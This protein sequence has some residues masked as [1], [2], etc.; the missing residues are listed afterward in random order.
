MAVPDESITTFD[1][2]E[3]AAYLLILPRGKLS[4]AGVNELK[5]FA[6]EKLMFSTAVE[7][8]ID[9]K[10]QVEVDTTLI[11]TLKHFVQ[12]AYHKEKKVI[13]TAPNELYKKAIQLAGLSTAIKIH[14]SVEEVL[15]ARSTDNFPKHC[16][17][18]LADDMATQLKILA[19]YL[20]DL[21]YRNM[22]Q[23]QDG[24]AAWQA[25]DS[26][27]NNN[28]PFGLII[29]DWYMPKLSGLELL[30]KIRADSR[31][32]DIPFIMQTTEKQMAN[33]SIAVQAGVDSYLIK[34]FGAE[35]IKQKMARVWESRNPKP[36]LKTHKLSAK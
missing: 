23:V 21:G 2:E 12:L 28:K 24:E 22:E 4:Y 5:T 33:V 11:E 32:K 13:V 29:S 19:K 15:P 6:S 1:V 20:G 10:E 27:C 8:I 14:R 35:A 17:I 9:F 30:K 18:L 26:S 34:P 36:S 31:T 7:I 25:I 16:R 3:T